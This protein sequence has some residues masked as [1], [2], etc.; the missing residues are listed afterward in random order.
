MAHCLALVVERSVEFV[1][2]S[3]VDILHFKEVLIKDEHSIVL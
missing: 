2:Q 1:F 3:N